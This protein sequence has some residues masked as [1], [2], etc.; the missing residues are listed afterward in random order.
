MDHKHLPGRGEV[1]LQEPVLTE[2]EKWRR[3]RPAFS[4][5]AAHHPD[6]A[7]LFRNTTIANGAEIEATDRAYTVHEDG[8]LRRQNSTRG[9]SKKERRA[10]RRRSGKD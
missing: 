7:A 5:V 3:S 10:A 9:L 4:S 2:E 6:G 8:S 1:V